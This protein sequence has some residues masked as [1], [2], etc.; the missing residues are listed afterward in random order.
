MAVNSCPVCLEKQRK[1]D[2]LEDEVKRLR[3]VLGR[4]Q[5]KAQDGLFGSSTPSSKKPVKK[6]IEKREGKP[7]GARPGHKGHGRKG[8]EEGTADRTEFEGKWDNK[9]P[10]IGQSWRRNWVFV[11]GLRSISQR[12]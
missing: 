11:E 12:L 1:I 8:H 10:T 5:R 9:Y 2:E 3:V 4:E 7:K 6:G